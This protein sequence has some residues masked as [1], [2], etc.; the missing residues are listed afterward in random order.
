MASLFPNPAC[1]PE[2]LWRTPHP[3]QPGLS[4]PACVVAYALLAPWTS[5]GPQSSRACAR[6]WVRQGQPSTCSG[7]PFELQQ[8]RRPLVLALC[9][10]VPSSLPSSEPFNGAGTNI[11]ILQV[12][13]GSL[14][15]PGSLPK[16]HTLQVRD[17]VSSLSYV[18]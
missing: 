6:H 16:V 18:L 5:S 2:N 11:L 8:I 13:K 9:H 1:L 4:F 14:V 3:H 17:S 7:S 15:R 12:R 10:S